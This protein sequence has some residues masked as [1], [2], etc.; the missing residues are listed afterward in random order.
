MHTMAKISMLG[1]LSRLLLGQKRDIAQK[2]FDEAK[3]IK[4]KAIVTFSEKQ[5]KEYC[6]FTGYQKEGIPPTFPYALLTH[7]QFSMVTDRRFPFSPFGIIHKSERIE[8][9][10]PLRPGRWEMSCSIPLLRKVKRGYEIEIIS[11]LKID[12]IIAW[13][14]TTTAFK[15]VTKG[16]GR[17]HFEPLKNTNQ[18]QWNLSQSHGLK[19]AK[20]SNNFDL[21]HLS[22]F[23]A[24]LMGLKAPIMHGMF[25]AARGVSELKHICYPFK[26]DFRFV[27]PIYLPAKVLYAANEQGFQVFSEN[28]KRLHLEATIL[29]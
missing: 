14:S 29:K 22:K 27:A 25:T 19:Y 24:K 17:Y 8:T 28:G 7:L 12:G 13:R 21:I 26:I 9:Y 11:V 20:L 15:Q 2:Y 4:R 16:I 10:F 1:N 6:A 5:L 3:K 23:T 18:T